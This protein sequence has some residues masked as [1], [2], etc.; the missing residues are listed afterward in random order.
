MD[1]L[2]LLL[3][4]PA[5]VVPIVLLFGFAGCS[6]NPQQVA[7]APMIVSA[8]PLDAFTVELQWT[9]SNGAPATYEVE[10]TKGMDPPSAPIP[11]VSMPPPD[12]PHRFVDNPLEGGTKTAIASERSLPATVKRRSGPILP[13]LKPSGGLSP[14][15]FSK[16]ESTNRS[17]AIASCSV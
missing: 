12:Q 1:W 16:A 4:V 13:L 6:Y 14:R 8:I 11:V 2:V 9:D 3:L 7:S 5:I 15:R 17:R 10:R